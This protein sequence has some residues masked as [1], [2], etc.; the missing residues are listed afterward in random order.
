MLS[1][2]FLRSRIPLTAP[3]RIRHILTHTPLAHLHT[4][5]PAWARA[6]R[7]ISS[8]TTDPEPSHDTQQQQHLKEAV[9]E[10]ILNILFDPKK[11]PK[12]HTTLSP[13]AVQP[14]APL[15]PPAPTARPDFDSISESIST[16]P[17]FP[18]EPTPEDVARAETLRLKREAR[19]RAK[20]MISEL[21]EMAEIFRASEESE[22]R[23]LDSIDANA[24]VLSATV[25]VAAE[26]SK[27]EDEDWFVG[28]SYTVTQEGVQE[29]ET[30]VFD[31]KEPANQVAPETEFTPRFMRAAALGE[32]RKDG[33]DVS[34]PPPPSGLLSP[35]DIITVLESERGGN[36]S[37]YDIS[38][39]CEWTET[40]IIVE[41]RSKKQLFS[42]MDGVRRLAKRFAATDPSLVSNMAIEGAQTEDWM[43][44]DLG[45]VVVHVMT[46]E[47]RWFYDLDSLW[48][49]KEEV[50]E[51]V[52]G[53]EAEEDAHMLEM[54]ERAWM[55]RPSTIVKTKQIEAGDLMEVG[56][57]EEKMKVAKNV[58]GRSK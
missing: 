12:Q 46:P 34:P 33:T 49:E 4:S 24:E 55:D 44:L 22:K 47:A 13:A 50:V 54:V 10:D 31:V 5:P 15:P 23:A 29:L 58:F 8:P 32:S 45:R 11:P 53:S 39:K 3:T 51:V 56:D 21:S 27:M 35:L 6:R 42:L 9:A 19:T 52:G 28:T 37:M 18:A 7:P 25:N 57:V 16:G 41:G 20:D 36:I 26:K 48:G 38:H 17:T 14:Q 43:V 1:A 2:A 30:P 40:L